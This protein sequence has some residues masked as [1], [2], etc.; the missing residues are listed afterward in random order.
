MG[1]IVLHLGRLSISSYAA[2]MGLAIILGLLVT[3]LVSRWT[4]ADVRTVMDAALWALLAGI[5]GGRIAYV[6][7]YWPYFGVHPREILA[8]SQGGLAFQGSFMA[9]V[10]GLIGYSLWNQT[11]FWHLADML[12]PG[13][14]LGQAIGWIGCLLNGYGYGLVTRGFLAYDLRDI[15]GIMAFRYPTQAMMSAL[16]LVIFV[17]L[18]ALFCTRTHRRLAP[19]MVAVLYLLL[20][21]S[22]LFFLEFLRADETLYFGT[23][24]WSQVAEAGQFIVALLALLYLRAGSRKA[25]LGETA[26]DSS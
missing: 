10:L 23:L 6:G 3:Y 17:L 15:Y 24:R 13:L 9:G 12:A 2:F 18:A 14:A 1:P 20:N 19:G 8:L 21:S 4:K 26:P 7:I 11:S 25:T 16:N 22:G 5:I